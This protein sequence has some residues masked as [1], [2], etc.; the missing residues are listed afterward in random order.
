M[1]VTLRTKLVMFVPH[2]KMQRRI[3]VLK[4]TAASVQSVDDFL[5]EY[6]QKGWTVQKFAVKPCL[7][8]YKKCPDCW[9][10]KT[11]KEFSSH[12]WS[13]IK[14][15]CR[16]C[17]QA[18]ADEQKEEAIVKKAQRAAEFIA[19]FVPPT[20]RPRSCS[21]ELP[22]PFLDFHRQ[23][24]QSREETGDGW[25][26]YTVNSQIPLNVRAAPSMTAPVVGG[27]RPGC[28]VAQYASWNSGE[29]QW[30]RISCSQHKQQWVLRKAPG[31]VLDTTAGALC[32]GQ[33]LDQDGMVFSFRH[34][35][36]HRSKV[37][38]ELMWV[39]GGQ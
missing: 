39:I 22:P 15:K 7:P 25:R 18:R 10:P 33:C 38:P 32:V 36:Q 16:C 31:L 34:C 29:Y 27:L 30:M 24:L 19:R 35:P 5:E 2:R 12:Q 6:K 4:R 23:Q 20:P 21:F 13:K 3:M 17:T 26:L 1:E 11:K 28:A 37:P 14:P 9:Q 8:K